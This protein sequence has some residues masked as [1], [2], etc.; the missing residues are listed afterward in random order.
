MIPLPTVSAVSDSETGSTLCSVQWLITEQQPDTS[1]HY[2]CQDRFNDGGG[3]LMG[4]CQDERYYRREA[5]GVNTRDGGDGKLT[6][7][8]T[9]DV[10]GYPTGVVYLDGRGLYCTGQVVEGRWPFSDCFVRLCKL[11][12]FV[13]RK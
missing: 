13:E 10:T 6:Y 11:Q 1:V 4:A 3:S 2:E 9:W 12:Y 8:L 7:E 5:S